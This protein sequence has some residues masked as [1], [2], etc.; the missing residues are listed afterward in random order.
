MSI[1][2][3]RRFAVLYR[4]S[5]RCV[6]CGRDSTKVEL[7]ADHVEPKAH[8]GADDTWNLVAACRGCNRA[9]RANFN[10]FFNLPPAVKDRLRHDYSVD[11]KA[12]E[13]IFG[14]SM[15]TVRCKACFGYYTKL[16]W[17]LDVF[18]EAERYHRIISCSDCG[19]V[20]IYR[21]EF[22]SQLQA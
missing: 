10:T 4:D 15:N 12:S 14:L 22:Q 11:Q 9:K 7:E 6:Y 21:D 5:F 20:K 13:F 2:P 19:E 3:E 8:G 17:S 16:K 1:S 18:E